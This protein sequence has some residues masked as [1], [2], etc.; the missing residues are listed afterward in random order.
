MFPVLLDVVAHT[1]NPSTAGQRQMD[2]NV[3]VPGQTDLHSKYQASWGY[4]VKKTL[5]Q[6]FFLGS[7]LYTYNTL[8][9]MSA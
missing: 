6:K 4:I 7:K 2:L 5:N 8:G 9:L 1:F 3:R